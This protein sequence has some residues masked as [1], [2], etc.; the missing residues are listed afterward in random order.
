[1]YTVRGEVIR[2]FVTWMERE[3]AYSRSWICILAAVAAALRVNQRMLKQ[4][5][6]EV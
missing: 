6:D 2:I 3:I 4:T 1:M 5:E